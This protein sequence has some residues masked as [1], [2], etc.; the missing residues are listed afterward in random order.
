MLTIPAWL[1]IQQN[2]LVLHNIDPELHII[3]ETT[4]HISFAQNVQTI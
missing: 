2:V 3:F 1:N 4:P